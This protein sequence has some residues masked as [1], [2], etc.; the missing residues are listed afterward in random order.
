M[1]KERVHCIVL[2][3]LVLLVYIDFLPV[4]SAS[5]SMLMLYD[6]HV[7]EQ[8]QRRK[9]YHKLHK[10]HKLN[11]TTPDS[12]RQLAA[13]YIYLYFK[14]GVPNMQALSICP[15]RNKQ[16]NHKANNDFLQP[17]KT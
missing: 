10:L 1:V 8:N 9:H 12:L 5:L 3:L 14:F 7:W 11:H 4:N 16:G 17:Y 13:L 15:I 2:V 6:E